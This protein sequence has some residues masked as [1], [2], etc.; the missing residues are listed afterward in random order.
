[1]GLRYVVV[2]NISFFMSRL[3]SLNPIIFSVNAYFTFRVIF[4]KFSSLIS[5]I[6]A[7]SHRG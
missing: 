2:S 3:Y 4:R 6:R 1:M 5:G 7:F